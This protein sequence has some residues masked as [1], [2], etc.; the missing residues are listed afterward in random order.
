MR[1][2][3]LSA[4]K[5][6][7]YSSLTAAFLATHPEASG[8]TIYTNLIPDR[9]L[10]SIGPLDTMHLDLD[11]DLVTDFIFNAS[12]SYSSYASASNYFHIGIQGLNGD[13]V[14]AYFETE[15]LYTFLNSVWGTVSTTVAKIFNFGNL[16]GPAEV[17]KPGAQVFWHDCYPGYFSTLPDY[18]WSAGL[19]QDAIKYIGFRLKNGPNKYYGWMRVYTDDIPTILPHPTSITIMDY[20]INAT[21]NATVLAGVVPII[22]WPGDPTTVWAST[23]Q[24]K[25][26][27]S[28]VEYV[29]QYEVR[30]M[31][32]DGIMSTVMV[33]GNKTSVKLTG[34]SC[35][36]DYE[37][38][39]RSILVDAGVSEFT[40]WQSF[41][42][43][44]CRLEPES[45]QELPE[46]TIYAFANQLN[47]VADGL[48]PDNA[49]LDVFDQLGQ[50]V[51]TT[52][53]SGNSEIYD[54]SLPT[55]IYTVM[56]QSDFDRRIQRIVLQ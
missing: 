45:G 34:L 33:P 41:T 30:Y 12:F 40:D 56:I 4:N 44:D 25:L 9:V 46:I 52:T 23:T 50:R 28:P 22:V 19:A 24:A 54:L 15:V 48:F 43:L 47:V 51:F 36:T 6:K 55:G 8:Q 35:N 14:A 49:Q 21:P 3:F 1:T 38:Q 37:W 5:L 27:W 29:Q 32:P 7:A 31:A 20:A 18:C 53:F 10:T 39:I 26:S 17:F 2:N 11:N 42:T 16:I 13:R